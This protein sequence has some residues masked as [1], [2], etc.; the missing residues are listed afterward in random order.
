MKV[1][2]LTS[3]DIIYD[4]PAKEVILPGKDG[5]FSVLDF[6]QPFLYRLGKGRLRVIPYGE[7]EKVFELSLEDGLAKMSGNFLK[8]L[9]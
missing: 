2:V 9:I 3:K 5:E 6:H 8:I 7:E 4:G 1:M